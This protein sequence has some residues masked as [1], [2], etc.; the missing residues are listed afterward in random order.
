MR[1]A[2]SG[3]MER[4]PT[5]KDRV[6]ESAQE[7]LDAHDKLAVNDGVTCPCENCDRARKLIEAW[8]EKAQ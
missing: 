5:T 4:L 2:A 3:A 6:I 1:S 8:Q 7:L